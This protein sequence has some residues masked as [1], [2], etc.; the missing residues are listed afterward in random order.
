[1]RDAFG[2]SK[3]MRESPILAENHPTF[4]TRPA[5]DH[6]LDILVRAVRVAAYVAD[7]RTARSLSSD[8][9]SEET[10]SSGSGAGVDDSESFA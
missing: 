6:L 5:N 4:Y 10:Y 7:S 8:E 3:L 2:G 1:V 9:A